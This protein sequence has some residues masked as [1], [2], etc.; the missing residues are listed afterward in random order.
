MKTLSVEAARL[1]D[2]AFDEGS[3]VESYVVRAGTAGINYAQWTVS[4]VHLRAFSMLFRLAA[5]FFIS[6]CGAAHTA[7]ITAMPLKDRS[8]LI[9]IEGDLKFQDREIFLTKIAPFDG[10]IVILNS[11]GGSA[12][13]GIEIGRA[14]RM[15]GFKTFVESGTMC[16]SACAIAWL[17]GVERL[18]GKAAIIGF[19][20][21][22]T[23]KSGAAVETGVG[24]AMYGAYLAQLGLSER[25][26][27]YLSDA[28]PTSMNWLTPADAESIGISLRVFDI[29]PTT[30]SGS[31]SPS[32]ASAPSSNPSVGTAPITQSANMESRSRDFVIALNS[33]L[34]GPTDQYLKILDGIY[35]DPVVYF[36][37]QTA[38]ADIIN[39]L[40][41]FIE[42]WPDRTYAVRPDSLRVQCSHETSAC[43]VSGQL[44]FSAK[45]MARNQWS[46]GTATFE[47][48]L[49]FRPNA[50]WPIIVNEG[51]GVVDRQMT[52][53]QSV[54]PRYPQNFDASQ[55]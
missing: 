33:L 44:E 13:A 12:Y 6:I 10:G 16:A 50:R 40:T 18:V 29:K 7:E 2:A 46:R 4:I 34:S 30:A 45:S 24:N 11:N 26:I 19:H 9:M 23:T 39:Q 52:A 14:I 43:Q 3:I 27:V 51:G 1:R 5:I 31:M 8:G 55:R 48:L 42:R 17:G 47:Y 36:G 37:K 53:L 35:A 32:S 22:Y 15:R 54:A 41:K 28:A 38:R 25:A 49:S 20:A 21:V